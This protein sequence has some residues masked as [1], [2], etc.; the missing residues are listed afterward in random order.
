M[1][2]YGVLI[3]DEPKTAQDKG[4]K[5]PRCPVCDKN[6]RPSVQTGVPVCPQ[7]GTLPFEGA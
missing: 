7:C 4:Q 3:E 6:L 1:E 2:K 5:T